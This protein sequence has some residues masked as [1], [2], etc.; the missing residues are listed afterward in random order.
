MSIGIEL[1]LE[2]H[3]PIGRPLILTA[4]TLT[5]G[6]APFGEKG[7]GGWHGGRWEQAQANTVFGISFIFLYLITF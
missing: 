4:S 6:W 1:K 5:P 7:W 3:V 2:S